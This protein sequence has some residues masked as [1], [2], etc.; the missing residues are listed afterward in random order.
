MKTIL[1]TG[2]TG[3]LGRN[4]IARLSGRPDI[5]LRLGTRRPRPAGQPG[6][7]YVKTDYDDP[8]T[9]LAATAGADAVLHLAAAVAATSYEEFEKANVQPTRALVSACARQECSVK[10]F[11]LA[12]SLAAAGAS[13]DAASPRTET[14]PEAPVS[15]YGRTKLAAERELANLPDRVRRVILRPAV[16]Y[17]KNDAGIDTLA[18]W[19]RRGLMLSAG[20]ADTK[21]SFIFVE[22]AADCFITA[23]DNAD[24]L[25]GGKFFIC[26][27]RAY[28]WEYFISTMAI[29]MHKPTP[30]I[31]TLPPAVVK[32]AGN[33]YG[34]LAALTG[35]KPVFNADKAREAG[36]GNWTASPA[37]WMNASG[38]TGW[39]TLADGL[40]KTFS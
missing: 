28:S 21:F 27:P 19:V 23:L 10:T 40:R 14:Q 31:A 8:Q 13:P 24:R 35:A 36:A 5:K 18:A 17:G 37:A 11:V 32:F 7:E 38:K 6:V 9:L 29:A 39:V 33:V 22:D 1:I 2:A 3:F 26:E 34:K 25:N 30:I 4:I 20:P 12:S 16:V 15:D